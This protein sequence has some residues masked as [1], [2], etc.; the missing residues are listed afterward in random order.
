MYIYMIVVIILLLLITLIILF[1]FSPIIEGYDARYTDT[2]F[3]KCAEFCKT[4]VGCSGFGYDKVNRLCYPSQLPILGKPLDSIFKK[5]Y[6]YGNATCN[7]VKTIDSSNITPTFTDRRSNSIYVCTESH[8]KQPQYYFHNKGVFENIGEG[9]NIDSLF[10][11]EEYEVKPY[12]W[13]R[14]RF[15]YDQMDLLVKER[16]NQT[17]TPENI[18]D[19]N[20]IINF[21]PTKAITNEEIV[22]APKIDLKPKLDF[23]V[24]TMFSNLYDTVKKLAPAVLIPTKKY[25][26]QPPT[27]QTT[28]SST[29]TPPKSTIYKSNTDQNTGQYLL[30][31]KCVK[32]VGLND[33]ASYCS[34]NDECKGFEWNPSYDNNK[35]VC[36]P[37]KSINNFTVRDEAKSMGKFYEK[38]DAPIYGLSTNNNSIII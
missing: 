6:S 11:V 19:V 1:P 3:P 14:N 38:T 8:D 33:C 13:P 36:C 20:R 31:Y 30:D 24:G 18:T 37:Y 27:Q 29:V 4:T 34:G 26:V 16:E 12:N 28:A 32:D 10:D 21:V 25:E 35:N 2:D 5:E 15:D 17:F 9:K 7:K 23:N 22:I